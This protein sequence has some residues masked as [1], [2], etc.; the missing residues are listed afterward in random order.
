[1]SSVTPTGNSQIHQN[2]R[3]T[4]RGEGAPEW[5]RLEIKRGKKE[6]KINIP[7]S[8]SSGARGGSGSV[9]CQRREEN[10]GFSPQKNGEERSRRIPKNPGTGNADFGK[11]KRGGS[12]QSERIRP[13]T[14][15]NSREGPELR[16]EREGAAPGRRTG[17]G[18]ETGTRT[19]TETET[20]T[21]RTQRDPERKIG[22]GGGNP[23]RATQNWF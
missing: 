8:G 20:G 1:M 19:G 21:G 15:K 2:S 7:N 10:P 12:S 6:K 13:Q 22:S 23:P 11:K 14:Q 3:E 5:D 9:K 18:T 16:W 4:W 17:T